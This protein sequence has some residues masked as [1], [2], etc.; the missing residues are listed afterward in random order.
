[1]LTQ[2]HFVVRWLMFFFAFVICADSCI[3][4]QQETGGL[5]DRNVS[6]EEAIELALKN[7]HSIRRAGLSV[8]SNRI[9]VKSAKSDFQIKIKPSTELGVDS[10]EQFWIGG[11]EL[12][13]KSSLGVIASVTSRIEQTDEQYRSVVGASLQIPILRGFG[14]DYNKDELYSSLFELQ[15][16]QLSLYTEQARVVLD[17]VTTVYEIIKSQS[18]INLLTAQRILL[19]NHLSLTK[20]KEK[21]GLATAMDLYRVQLRLKEVQNELTVLNEQIN[22]QSDL[23]KD[24]LSVPMRGTLTVIAPI[25][26]R[27]VDTDVDQ[28]IDIALKNRIEIESSKRRT[29]EYK[30]KLAIAKKEILPRLDLNIGYEKYGDNRSF[31]LD[32]ETVNVSIGGSTDLFRSREKAAFEQARINL[33]QSIIDQESTKLSVIKEVRAQIN[34]MEK[35]KQ[36]IDDRKEQKKQAEGKYRL[37]ASRFKHQMTDNFDLIESQSEKQQVASDL[38]SDVIDYIV[39]T[40][41]FRQTLG[42]L[43]KR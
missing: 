41:K 12:S 32:E 6:L 35:K 29:F 8:E 10:G 24:I 38:I 17:T 25:E 18:M 37:A 36:L 9:G 28:A 20:I 21:T 19:N 30:R 33:N 7:N 34:Q 14:A 22:T 13:K 27:P 2:S 16:A 1:M 40:Y 31:D 11:L 26:Y 3:S 39:H 5:L 15:S 42:T 43:I 4:G 23:L